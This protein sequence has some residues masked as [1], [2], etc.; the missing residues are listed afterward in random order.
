MKRKFLFIL[1]AMGLLF[2]PNIVLAKEN[3]TDCIV[4]SVYFD[5]GYQAYYLEAKN[6]HYEND[7]FVV[8]LFDKQTEDQNIT[9]QLSNI[10]IDKQIIITWE[11]N[12]T[13]DINDDNILSFE[14]I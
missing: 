14:M 13:I 3:N 2:K 8:W 9:E 11:D 4:Q 6:E 5:S 10:F 1:L 7:N 12:D